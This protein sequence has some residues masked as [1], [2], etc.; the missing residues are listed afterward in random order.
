MKGT[1]FFHLEINLLIKIIWQCQSIKFVV[2]A[3][4]NLG[5]LAH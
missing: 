3:N 1:I 5:H 4:L 2:Y